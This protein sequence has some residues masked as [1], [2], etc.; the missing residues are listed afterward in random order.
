M[1]K[2]WLRCCES[3]GEVKV[4]VSSSPVSSASAV[5]A[6]DEIWPGCDATFREEE[7]AKMGGATMSR[8]AI[9]CAVAGIISYI[10][11]LK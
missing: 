2:Q 4:E 1:E 7:E 5:V 3:D 11:I 6:G 8:E 10:Y 9:W